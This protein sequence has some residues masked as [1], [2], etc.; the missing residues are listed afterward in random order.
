M[1]KT[2]DKHR[3][4]GQTSEWKRPNFKPYGHYW[5]V[6]NVAQVFPSLPLSNDSDNDCEGPFWGVMTLMN[7]SVNIPGAC[8]ALHFRKSKSF[9]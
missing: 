4:L 9:C 8:K 2:L 3:Q 7:S 1:D 6:L 5:L